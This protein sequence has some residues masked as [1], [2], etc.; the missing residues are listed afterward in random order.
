VPVLDAVAVLDEEAGTVTL[1]LVNRDQSMPV[2]VDVDLRGLPGLTV[3]EHTSLSDD[4]PDA[5]NSAAE[6]DRVV[7]VG[8]G[9]IAVDSGRFQVVLPALSWNML[10]ARPATG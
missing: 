4:D 2:T 10:R 9:D 1:F 8:R 3:V 5:V 6:P 7:P